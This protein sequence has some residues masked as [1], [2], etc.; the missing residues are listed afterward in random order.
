M[1]TSLTC[2]FLAGV[3]FAFFT[4]ASHAQD[5]DGR[6][7]LRV[8]DMKHQLR[9][10]AT[11]RFAGDVA[12]ESC[13]SGKWRRVVVSAKTAHD[14]KFFPLSEPLAYTLAGGHLTFGRASVCDGYLFLSGQWKGA[15]MRGTYSEVSIESGEKLG[16]F[17]LEKVQ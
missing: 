3:L 12:T 8:T 6:W 10:E 13:M 4:V 15:T 17:T 1:L 7:R 2:R 9:V 5:L 14:E 16:N 11:I